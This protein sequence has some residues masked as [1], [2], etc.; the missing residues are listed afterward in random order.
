[1]PRFLNCIILTLTLAACSSSTSTTPIESDDDS[2]A[3]V[4][5]QVLVYLTQ[6]DTT[7]LSEIDRNHLRQSV[8]LLK[9]QCDNTIDEDEHEIAIKS[10]RRKLFI[11]VLI[12]LILLWFMF[13]YIEKNT[14]SRVQLQEALNNINELRRSLA[15]KSETIG[16]D[17]H[18]D[19]ATVNHSNIESM[20]IGQLKTRLRDELLSLQ[21]AG[22]ASTDIPPVIL[23]SAAYTRL[24]SLIKSE[25]IIADSNPLWDEI[26]EVVIAASP[27]FKYHLQLLTGGSLKAADY[28]LALLV[29]CGVTPTQMSLL[30]GRAKGTISYRREAL[31]QKIFGEKLGVKVIDDVIRLL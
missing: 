31:C 24:Q 18:D 8:N 14:T 11:S 19:T 1:M 26:E 17:D 22:S 20:G 5:C 6:L 27:D 2:V 13:H 15:S 16:V 10:L 30:V 25:K 12:C 4:P 29:K 28:R 7:Q 9:T 23:D 3:T 21:R